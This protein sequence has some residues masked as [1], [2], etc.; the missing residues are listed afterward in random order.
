MS[1]DTAPDS[2]VD[3][4][5]ARHLFPATGDCAYFNTAAVGLSSLATTSAYHRYI[6]EWSRSG[7]D[8]VRVKP[9]QKRHG[10]RSRRSSVP[11]RPTS[12]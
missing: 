3:V 9:R 12:R 11:T 4:R 7:L 6:D 2:I 5:N 10:R 1:N 8:Y